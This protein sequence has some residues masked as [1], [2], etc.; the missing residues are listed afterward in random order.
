MKKITII[1]LVAMVP[2]LTMAQKRSK[3]GKDKLEQTRNSNNA[4]YEFMVITGMTMMA[5]GT[6]SNSLGNSERV[7]LSSG[8]NKMKITFDFGGIRNEDNL[9]LTENRYK[10]MSHAVNSAAANGWE[11]VNANVIDSGDRRAHYYY[12]RKQK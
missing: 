9:R 6:S 11:F 7:R 8:I 1:M 12:M 3:K 10:S 5:P 4:S 2:L